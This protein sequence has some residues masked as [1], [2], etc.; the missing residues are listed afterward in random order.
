[1][2]LYAQRVDRGEGDERSCTVVD[3]VTLEAAFR[4]NS[5]SV[6]LTPDGSRSVRLRWPQFLRRRDACAANQDASQGGC[7]FT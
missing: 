4:K 6:K 2:S 3:E 1:M 7:S 5:G